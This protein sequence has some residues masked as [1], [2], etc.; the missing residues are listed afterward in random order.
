MCWSILLLIITLTSELRLDGKPSF[1]KT[2]SSITSVKKRDGIPTTFSNGMTHGIKKD[3]Q[4]VCTNY[5]I[6]SFRNFHLVAKLV[7]IFGKT[8]AIHYI[9]V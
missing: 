3:F 5:V 6:Y 7:I 8:S 9:N 1:N 2:I 4:E